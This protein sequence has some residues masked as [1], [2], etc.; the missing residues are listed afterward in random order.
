MDFAEHPP[1]ECVH[2][3]SKPLQNTQIIF[4]ERTGDSL[5]PPPSHNQIVILMDFSFLFRRQ[6][7]QFDQMQA[8][9]LSLIG[10][11]KNCQVIKS[12]TMPLV[13]DY[14]SKK[15]INKNTTSFH[16]LI[17]VHTLTVHTHRLHYIH[18]KVT[19]EHNPLLQQS[20]QNF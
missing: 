20:F 14:K 10:P 12:T 7:H 15:I 18:T 2:Y 9:F 8:M 6:T 5:L 1:P 3:N 19:I 16:S 13:Q 17:W 4:T 11:V